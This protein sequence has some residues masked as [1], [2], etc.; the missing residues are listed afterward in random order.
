MTTWRSGDIVANGIN[1]HFTRTGGDSPPLVLAHGMAD[2]GLCWSRVA[3]AL[4]AEY[5][6]IMPDARS[7]GRS[8]RSDGN[9]DSEILA[10]DLAALIEALGLRRPVVGGHSMGAMTTVFLAA[11]RPELLRAAILEDPPFWPAASRLTTEE[12][13]SR[14]VERRHGLEYDQ[15]GGRE[16]LLARGRADNPLWA[17][18]EFEP[19][20]DSKMAVDCVA[21][22]VL[23]QTLNWREALSRIEAPA[24]L[25][26]GDPELGAIVTPEVAEE[27]SQIQPLVQ[28]VRIRG[29]GHSIRREQFEPYLEAMQGFL[30][31]VQDKD[32]V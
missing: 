11:S 7:H 31:G 24:L 26:T 1:L 21:L 14:L 25:I 29:S 8:Q 2:S 15:A 20:V 19:W 12:V 9:Y 30:A 3:R 22:P 28:V 27:A 10:R 18:E 6:I 23:S 17:D 4:E 16:A 13:E 32:A 5:D